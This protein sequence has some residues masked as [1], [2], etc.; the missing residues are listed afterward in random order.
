MNPTVG[1]DSRPPA[2]N[3][4]GGPT[5]GGQPSAPTGREGNP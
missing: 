4:L 2:T 3:S 1:A 5:S